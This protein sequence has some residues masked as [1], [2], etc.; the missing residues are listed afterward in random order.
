MQA[1]LVFILLT[2]S[3]FGQPDGGNFRVG[4]RHPT[5]KEEACSSQRWHGVAFAKGHGN[6]PERKIP[7]HNVGDAF[8]GTWKNEVTHRH[9]CLPTG[10]V[11]KL[12]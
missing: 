5:N 7:W 3:F 12:L 9:E 4:K 10:I 1:L 11:R 2:K 8:R 6:L